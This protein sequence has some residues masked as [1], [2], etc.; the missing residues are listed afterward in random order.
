MGE[1]FFSSCFGGHGST[2]PIDQSGKFSLLPRFPP[3]T[4]WWWR[5][6][7]YRLSR[8]CS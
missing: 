2:I 1:R 7:L 5:R 6:R 3:S 4:I 8:H